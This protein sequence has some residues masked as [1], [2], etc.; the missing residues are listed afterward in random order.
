MPPP[1]QEKKRE[2][3]HM[4]ATSS[5]RNSA[6]CTA[7]Q[8]R[9]CHQSGQVSWNGLCHN[10]YYPTVEK[11]RRA[12]SSTFNSASNSAKA[13]SKV[14]FT[15]SAPD[16]KASHRCATSSAR[17]VEAEC[18]I[19]KKNPSVPTALPSTQ[20]SQAGVADLDAYI[21]RTHKTG[22]THTDRNTGVGKE[23]LC[24]L[25]YASDVFAVPFFN[26]MIYISCS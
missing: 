5:A 4:F 17:Q 8:P 12:N 3:N 22:D 16:K 21:R 26:E 7:K 20:P 6:M 9:I 23:L 19:K 11:S 2:E 10:N 13:R 1:P 24:K 25:K 14:C 18:V 15:S